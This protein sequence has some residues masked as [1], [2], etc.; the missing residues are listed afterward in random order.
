MRWVEP[1]AIAFVAAE[2]QFFVKLED[3][4]QRRGTYSSVEAMDAVEEP[5]L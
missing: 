2:I 5:Q 4:P 1:E 3:V